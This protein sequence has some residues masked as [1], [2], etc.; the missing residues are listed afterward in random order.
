MNTAPNCPICEAKMQKRVAKKGR[1]KGNMFWGCRYYPSCKGTLDYEESPTPTRT[2]LDEMYVKLRQDPTLTT[3]ELISLIG[4]EKMINHFGFTSRSQLTAEIRRLRREWVQ[5]KNVPEIGAGELIDAMEAEIEILEQNLMNQGASTQF[6]PASS[7]SGK[8]QQIRKEKEVLAQKISAEA[9]KVDDLVRQLAG[10]E[11][12]LKKMRVRRPKTIILKG[13]G[14]KEIRRVK[15]EN[16]H[17]VYEDVLALADQR[18][19][20][21]LAGPAGCGKSYLAEQ[22]AQDLNLEFSS[23]NCSAGMSEGHLLGRLLPTGTG[24]KFEWS[25]AAFVER[26]EQGGIFVADEVD[27][28]DPNV[29][30]VINT[31]IANGHMAVSNRIKK[32]TATQHR[33][34]ILIACANTFGRGNDRLYVGRNQLDEATLDRFRI[35]TIEMDYDSGTIELEE[36]TAPYIEAGFADRMKENGGIEKELCPDEELRIR[37]QWYREKTV[38][39]RL[40]RIVSTRFLKDAY[41]M[42]TNANWDDARIDKALFSGWTK[43]EIQ[44]VRGS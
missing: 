30:L 27:G 23:I 33:D 32:P 42:K 9:N 20:I 19:N 34:F 29:M 1:N 36:W 35:G 13:P 11:K 6:L 7:E 28:A 24:G 3:D 4:Q 12:E 26:Y 40:E 31:A 41:D 16:R 39:N 22:I 21:L 37:M 14:E 44:L 25:S 8:I 5:N 10:K 15:T 17:P 38:K 2:V 18:K 43:D